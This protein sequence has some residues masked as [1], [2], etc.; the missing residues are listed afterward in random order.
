MQ[1]TPDKIHMVVYVPHLQATTC[2]LTK[3][4]ARH[5]AD[6]SKQIATL[7]SRFHCV[8]VSQHQLP[9][10]L[11]ILLCALCMQ[12]ALM[13]SDP[14]HETASWLRKQHGAEC[15]CMQ[16]EASMRWKHDGHMQGPDVT[17]F[18]KL[19]YMHFAHSCT[20]NT[21]ESSESNEMNVH[22]QHADNL[23]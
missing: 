9:A 21:I 14:A 12:L 20:N 23:W 18:C 3:L 15:L 17:T 11:G 13:L 1:P 8:S 22:F 10:N 2:W 6:W 16:H 5:K 4:A 19:Q 7:R